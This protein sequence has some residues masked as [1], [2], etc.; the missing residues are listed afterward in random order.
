MK[1][2]I[3]L[4]QK[5][6]RSYTFYSPIQKGKYRL[7]DLA[8][9]LSRRLPD[10]IIVKTAD[11]RELLIDTA[12]GSYKYVYF[13][14]EYEPAISSIFR[15]IIDPGDICFDIGANIG[16][17]A[18]LFQK[19]VGSEGE[20]HAFEPVPHI[21]E[22]LKRNVKLNEPPENVKL[23]N[24]ALGDVEKNVDLHVFPNI[25][26]GHASISTFNH[27]DFEV[28][29]S[30]MTT[31]DSYLSENKI[32]NVKLVKI[33]VE[34]AELM[35]LKGAS[36]LFDQIQLPVFEIEMALA[37]TRGFNYLPNDLIEYISNQ[38]D[39]DFFAIDEK[40]AGL[41][42]IKCFD[43][44]D[45]GANVLCLPRNFDLEKISNWLS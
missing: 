40:Y 30:R 42:Q 32:E 19:L 15:E 29:P 24:F 35:T 11:G 31:L 28:F 45:I 8:L 37:T 7:S 36:K 17:H 4:I 12:N 18:T 44:Q 2:D 3:G 9:R 27:K 43:S 10:E 6:I 34:G 33:D 20:V 14:G 23:N 39:Y 25:P 1:K 38:A 21:F 26:N 22:H 41:R 13:L 16:W 5:L